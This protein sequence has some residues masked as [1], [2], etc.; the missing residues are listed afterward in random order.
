M[1]KYEEIKSIHLELT[2]KCQASCPMCIRT[3]NKLLTNSELSIQDIKNIFPK[4]FIKE[5]KNITLCG[6]F[7]E[8]IVAKDCIEIVE[9]F[10]YTNP[11][12]QIS[13]NTNAGARNSDFWIDL[14]SLLDD[15]HSYIVFGID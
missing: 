6:N 8:P 1:Y 11:K 2:E 10:K 7:G 5:L 12:I 9:Y 13:I 15:G 3:G 4:E 14:A